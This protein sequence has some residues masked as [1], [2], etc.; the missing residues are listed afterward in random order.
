MPFAGL[1]VLSL[2][3]RRARDVE[4]LIL[5]Q[6]G[7]P[8][9]APSVKERAVDDHSI[10]FRFVEQLEAGA[11]EMV[12]C[13]TGVGLAFL[14][15]AVKAEMPV[16]RLADALRRA[17]VVA[18]G[19]KPIA[20]LRSLQ[21]PVGVAIPEPN[22]WKEVVAGV[23]ARAERRIAIL[24]YGRPNPELTA[25]LESLGCTVMTVSLY[26]WELPEDIEPLRKAA[27][28]LTRG[29]FDLILFTSSVQFD[30][31]LEVARSLGIESEVLQAL[32]ERVTIASIGPVTTA[33]LASKGLTP[34]I[35]PKSANLG[36]LVMAAAG[37]G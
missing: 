14:R 2:E 13:M 16:E 25:A 28:G 33:A 24:E 22:T 18:R 5:R 34:Q 17:T 32:A 6:G 19:P 1:R 9:V 23:K 11:F 12:V 21:V 27:R 8:F 35:V 29:E 31:L 3:S 7:V 4:S 20:V 26:R 37:R 15:D 10:A 36:A 30:H